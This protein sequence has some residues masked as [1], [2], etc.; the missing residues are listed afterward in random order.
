MICIARHGQNEDNANGILN[1]HRDLPLT[2]IGRNQAHQIAKK[3]QE[4][5]LQINTVLSSPLIR[6]LDTAKTISNVNNLPDPEVQYELI[7][8]DFGVMTGIE[9]SRIEELCHQIL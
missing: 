6:A 2:D 8:R 7:E 5:K 1:G 4:A 3:I 9:Q